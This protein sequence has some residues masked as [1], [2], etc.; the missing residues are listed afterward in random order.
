MR[1]FDIFADSAC[2]LTDELIEKY[3]IGI[4]PYTCSIGGV[5]MEAYEKGVPF[6]ETA[7]KFYDAMR[8]GSETKTTL[9][10]AQKI[11]DAVTPSLKAGRD[12]LFVTISKN[13]SGTYSQALMAEKELKELFPDRKFVPVDS[14]H[15][16]MGEGLHVLKAAMLA[17]M[18]ES[19]EACKKWI[20]D[21]QLNIHGV[22]TVSSLKYLKRGGRISATLAIAGTLLNIKPVLHGDENGKLAFWCNERGRKKAIAK[23]AETFK[24]Y[25]I[26]PSNQTVA[27]AHADCPEDAAELEALVRGYGA[28]EVITNVYDICTGAH[29]GPGTLALFF[30][31]TPRGKATEAKE[32]GL[33]SG[34]K[35]KKENKA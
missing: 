29:A 35:A 34:I 1:N 25:A 6:K 24:K 27:I 26:N 17:D 11:I 9:V 33:F 16:S 8:E 22:F 7:K 14:F 19:I 30:Y 2:N 5:E 3:D 10:N 21:N 18:G 32:G 12:V 4:V 15:A 20:E 28:T 23:L 31:G 13:I